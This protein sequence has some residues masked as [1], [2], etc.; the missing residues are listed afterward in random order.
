MGNEHVSGYS[1]PSIS[2][3]IEIGCICNNAVVSDGMLIGQPTE[4]ALLILGMKVIC[5]LNNLDLLG[6]IV[7]V[8][9]S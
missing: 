5:F 9:N 4:G 3:V 6:L 1:H 7:F 2:R 8:D